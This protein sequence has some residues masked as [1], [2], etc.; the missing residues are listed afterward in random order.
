MIS[1]Y[2]AALK[3]IEKPN[4]KYSLGDLVFLK[5]DTGRKYQ[6]LIVDFELDDCNC[7]DYVCKWVNN[8]GTTERDAFPEETLTT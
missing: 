6:M 1:E 3:N 4:L 2:K 7:N 8:I 5:S